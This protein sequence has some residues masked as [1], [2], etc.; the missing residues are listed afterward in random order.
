ME[1]I[2]SIS[3]EIAETS[4]YLKPEVYNEVDDDGT[5][6]PLQSTVEE[7]LSTEEPTQQGQSQL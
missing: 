2:E 1:Q 4:E 3:A 6:E 5:Y 7:A